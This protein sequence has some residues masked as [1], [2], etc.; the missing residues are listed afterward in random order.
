M[1]KSIN[2]LLAGLFGVVSCTAVLDKQPL[3]TISDAQ[4]W[5]DPVMCDKYLMECYAEMG[6]Y[7]EMQQYGNHDDFA[8]NT[9][10]V[11]LG[12]FPGPT[13]EPSRILL[14][15]AKHLIELPQGQV[16]AV[17]HGRVRS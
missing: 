1:K 6:F 5:S 9:T 14:H 8:N 2:I 16:G 17:H 10:M 4:V 7:N 15:Q 12:M 11:S 13:G 3:D